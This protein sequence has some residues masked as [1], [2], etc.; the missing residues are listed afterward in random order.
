MSTVEP[1]S[2]GGKSKNL[3]KTPCS[4]CTALTC[5]KSLVV[6]ASNPFLL[7]NIEEHK[8]NECSCWT[9]YI[10]QCV[11]SKTFHVPP[12]VSGTK[13]VQESLQ[14]HQTAIFPTIDIKGNTE[15]LITKDSILKSFQQA[16]P[17]N[18]DFKLKIQK[19]KVTAIGI[20]SKLMAE[21]TKVWMMI[22]TLEILNI[23]QQAKKSLLNCQL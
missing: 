3:T 13:T 1:T 16:I 12:K 4:Q 10:R 18:K 8:K 17:K 23:I 19:N 21:L 22:M 7:M 11:V 14:C 6:C 20:K 5:A 9:D 15:N 2:G